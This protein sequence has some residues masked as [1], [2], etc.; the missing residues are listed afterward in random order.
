MDSVD[1]VNI[2]GLKKRLFLECVSGDCNVAYD[3]ERWVEGIGYFNYTYGDDP[4][5]RRAIFDGPSIKLLCY[6]ENDSTYYQNPAHDT[7]QIDTTFEVSVQNI[8]RDEFQVYPNPATKFL[9]ISLPTASRAIKSISLV[10]IT[11]RHVLRKQPAT[12]KQQ[13]TI[14]INDLPESIYFC[15]IIA[16]SGKRWR[17]KVMVE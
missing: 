6:K 5:T 8:V 14:R 17:R 4:F 10:D 2:G 1:S 3:N 12:A 16:E 11:G 9:H 7:C 13:T 15:H